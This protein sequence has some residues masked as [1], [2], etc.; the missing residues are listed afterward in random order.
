MRAPQDWPTRFMLSCP[1]AFRTPSRSSTITSMLTFSSFRRR[2]SARCRAGRRRAYGGCPPARRRARPGNRAQ[3]WAAVHHHQGIP[4]SHHPAEEA[5]ALDRLEPFEGGRQPGTLARTGLGGQEGDREDGGRAEDGI[6]GI[7]IG[8][9]AGHPS[10]VFPAPS[11]TG[12][13]GAYGR[14]PGPSYG[15]KPWICTVQGIPVGALKPSP[16]VIAP[17]H[18]VRMNI[19]LAP[20][21]L[22][23][24][25]L[26]AFPVAWLRRLGQR[27]ADPFLDRFQAYTVA[28]GLVSLSI[29]IIAVLGPA[30]KVVEPRRAL[31]LDMLA[32]LIVVPA[33]IVSCWLFIQ[34][35]FSLVQRQP[36]PVAADPR[37]LRV[38]G[39]VL[40]GLP[41]GGDPLFPVRRHGVDNAGQAFVRRGGGD[42]HAPGA[43]RPH[44]ATEAAAR[45]A[46]EAGEDGP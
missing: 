16:P 6:H 17:M 11:R 21:Y 28:A 22:S 37:V 18:T 12:S 31:H 27:H 5:G 7:S 3:A 14:S 36:P 29:L 9:R 8:G 42:V 34:F 30:L 45:M 2:R 38:L 13:K 46:A 10:L 15:E 43:G 40:P 32:A 35:A 44:P 39:P 4:P 41:G 25:L 24:L 33:L 1:K 20:V 26:A 23:A 19:A